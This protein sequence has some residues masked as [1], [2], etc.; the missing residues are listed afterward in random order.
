MIEI[1]AHA[2]GSV[3]AVRAQ[4]GAR[5][6]AVVGEHQGALKVAVAAPPEKGKANDAIAGVLCAALGLRRSQV[7]LIAG[8]TSRDKKFLV[9]GLA[10]AAALERI[11]AILQED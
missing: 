5:R 8:P 1:A 3:V 9:R 4:P 7:E 10:P 6:N 2:E 11:Q